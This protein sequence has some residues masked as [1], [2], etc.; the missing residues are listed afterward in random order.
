MPT[1]M[2][3]IWCAIFTPFL[4]RSGFAIDYYLLWSLDKCCC[5]LAYNLWYHTINKT[6][7]ITRGKQLKALMRDI[8]IV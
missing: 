5:W 4:Q 8:K 6:P 3:R 1:H 2:L 7:D